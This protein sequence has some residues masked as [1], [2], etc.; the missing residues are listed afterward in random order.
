MIIVKY[1]PKEVEVCN[2]ED[3]IKYLGVILSKRKLQK[4]K[5]NKWRIEKR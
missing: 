4:M 2:I 5:F 3:T 1:Q